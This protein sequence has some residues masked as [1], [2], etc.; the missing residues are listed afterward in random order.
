MPKIQGL[1]K[2]ITLAFFASLSRTFPNCSMSFFMSL[3]CLV[4]IIADKLEKSEKIR[5][6]L[7]GYAFFYSLFTLYWVYVPLTFSDNTLFLIPFAVV[8]LPLYISLYYFI[9][10]VLLEKLH[11]TL[12]DIPILFTL[13]ILSAEFICS[14]LFTGFPWMNTGY[15]FAADLTF[16]QIASVVG[17]K[18][19][20]VIVLL[21]SSSLGIALYQYY[22]TRTIAVKYVVPGASI[23]SSM[24]V[25]GLIRLSTA[26]NEDSDITVR[27]VQGSISQNER[28]YKSNKYVFDVYEKLSLQNSDNVDIIIWPEACFPWVYNDMSSGPIS[29]SISRITDRCNLFVTGII[30]NERGRYYNSMI[31]FSKTGV[32]FMYDKVHLLPFGEY[33]PL[34]QYIGWSAIASLISDFSAGVKNRAV[35]AGFVPCICYE[36]IFSDELDV[37]NNTQWALNI[38][39]DGWF[40][41]S[42]EN[43]QHDSISRVF[44]VEHGIPMVRVNNLGISSVYDA[45]GRRVCYIKAKIAETKDVRLPKRIPETFYSR[46]KNIT[47]YC[48]MFI[49]V[50]IGIFMKII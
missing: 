36:S 28:S 12:A 22:K 8:L 24:L 35:S 31:G 21:A 4:A 14:H 29:R 41:D 40:E 25:F 50:C 2:I 6:Y 43:F 27:I 46:F 13:L 18:G 39:N 34:K 7:Q 44:S 47:Y 19:V 26:H 48:L 37:T 16:L 9:C 45:Y 32:Q 3:I 17:I 15:S 1:I 42:N 20:G 11:K 30:R 10:G 49:L 38:T 23:I 33:M 5:Y